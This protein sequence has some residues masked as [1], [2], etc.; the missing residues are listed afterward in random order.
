MKFKLCLVV[1]VVL[2]LLS[3]RPVL[4]REWTDSSGTHKI[5]AELV[6]L[7]GEVVHLENADGKIVKVLLDKL[8]EV[9]QEFVRREMAAKAAVAPNADSEAE[10]GTSQP[11]QLPV[12]LPNKGGVS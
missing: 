9:D 1:L 5:E 3:L 12:N 11:R 6:K 7:D 10:P 2:C 8:S 4:A